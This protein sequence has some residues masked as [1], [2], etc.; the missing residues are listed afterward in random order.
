MSAKYLHMSE[1]EK[2][3]VMAAKPEKGKG[4]KVSFDVDEYDE[5]TEKTYI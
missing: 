3:N 4:I 1:M 5:K 2:V